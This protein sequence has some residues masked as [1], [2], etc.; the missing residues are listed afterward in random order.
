MMLK[1]LLLSL[2]VSAVL[3]SDI[4][5][6]QTAPYNSTSLCQTLQEPCS[7]VEQAFAIILNSEW[8][9][10]DIFL[11]NEEMKV[12]GS[13]IFG[14]SFP[15][16]KSINIEG[17]NKMVTYTSAAATAFDLSGNSLFTFENIKFKDN[18]LAVRLNAS[19]AFIGC[20]FENNRKCLDTRGGLIL[21][22]VSFN[23]NNGDS[24]TVNAREESF[25]AKSV[26]FDQNTNTGEG[27]I[28]NLNVA[29]FRI[30]SSNFTKNTAVN[31]SAGAVHVAGGVGEVYKSYFGENSAKSAA[32]IGLY[33]GASL[34]TTLSSFYKNKASESGG[35]LII[36]SGRSS[37]NDT[38][39]MENSANNGGVAAIYNADEELISFNR[40]NFTKNH[41][42]T[43]SDLWMLYNANI[44]LNQVV[45]T[46]SASPTFCTE[47]NGN[48]TNDFCQSSCRAPQCSLCPGL[49]LLDNSDT[50][51]YK[52]AGDCFSGLTQGCDHG[53]C[54]LFLDQDKVTSKTQCECDATWGSAHC[55]TRSWLF[56]LL[57]VTS[58]LVAL[59]IVGGGIFT[60]Q[61]HIRK[62]TAYAT[63]N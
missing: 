29:D 55:D 47:N 43:A 56:W 50:V 16:A 23:G 6:D 39:F 17:Y 26:I 28:L 25:V 52:G 18:Q 35:A 36:S 42:H 33:N 11:N 58:A 10:F 13:T 19:G 62:P 34:S 9:Q 14:A 48:K 44:I 61:N 15:Y 32:A 30:I 24:P 46:H 53:V 63:L 3:S 54:R 59:V 41:A 4:F 45:T 38:S 40:C 12:N 27:G 51:S 60:V 20:V 57:L 5:V 37:F 22:N 1:T 7:S 2:F 49:C 31:S 21:E 8:A